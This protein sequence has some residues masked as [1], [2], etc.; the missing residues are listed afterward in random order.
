[1][2]RLW[3]QRLSENRHD[4]RPAIVARKRAEGKAWLKKPRGPGVHEKSAAKLR[5]F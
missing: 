2:D 4:P 3:N 1:M 5:D